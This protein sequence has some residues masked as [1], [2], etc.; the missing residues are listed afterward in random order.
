MKNLY[1]QYDGNMPYIFGSKNLDIKQIQTINTQA[2]Y[3]A[4]KL[5]ETKNQIWNEALTFLGISNVTYQK[6]ERLISD[7]VM[8]SLGGTVMSRY[9]AL[10][11]RQRACDEINRMFGLD[12]SVDFQDDTSLQEITEQALVGGIKDE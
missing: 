8:R 12:M 10:N 5:T 11:E 9:S 6:K 3:V 4:D 2:P 7:E 1:L